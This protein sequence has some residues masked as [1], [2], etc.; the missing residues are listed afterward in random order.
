MAGALLFALALTG[1]LVLATYLIQ[2]ALLAVALAVRVFALAC[3]AAYYGA[4]LAVWCVWWLLD[5]R[6]AMAAA[7]D[8]EAGAA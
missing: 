4:C 8:A 1:A 7:Q 2:G 3:T 6:G 5:P